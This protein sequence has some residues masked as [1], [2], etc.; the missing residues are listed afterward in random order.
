[1]Q[2][3]LAALSSIGSGNVVVTQAV[4][5][6]WEVR[7][8]GTLAGVYQNQMTANGSGLTG[9]TSPNAVVTTLSLGGDNGNV[10]D[11]TDPDGIDTRTYYDP[12]GRTV[13]SIQDFTN[14]AV[15]S[16]SNKTTDYSYNSA[17]MTSLTAEMGS[18]IGETTQWNYGVSTSGTPDSTI[19]SNDIVGTTEE[20]NPSTG[21]PSTSLETTVTVNNLGETLTSTDPNGT[22][23][24]YTYDV[25]G[26][27][28]ADTVTTLGT[29]VD[30][31]VMKIGTSYTTLGAPYLITSYNSSG[32]V[33]NQVED[34][35]NGLD[36]LTYQY[37]STSGAVNTSTTPYVEYEYTDLS[38]GNN[39]RL[40]AVVY[41]EGYTVNYNYASGLNNNISRLSSLSDSTGTLE[42]Y[43]YLGLDTVV[44]MDHPESG[45]DLTYISQTGGTGSAGDQ[46]TGID[47]FGRVDEQNWYDPTTSSS[48]FDVQYGYDKDSN[49]LYRNDVFNTAMSELYS[50]DSLGQITTFERG[51]LNSGH[52]AIT[53]PS[54]SETWTYDALGN[55]TQ[56]S[57]TTTGTTTVNS[58]FNYDNQIASLSSGTTPAYDADGNMTTDQS[59]L[60]YTYDAWGRLVTVKNSG[61]TTLES[62]SYDGMGDALTNT[63]SGT[64]T[65]FYYS[66]MGQVLEEQANST[67]YYIQR[68]VWSPA[69]VNKMILRDND[70]SGTGLTATG[71]GYT[72]LFAL[73]DADYNV[74]AL[75]NTSGV[76]VER[77]VYDPFGSV[78]ILTGSYGSRSSSSYN[79]VYGFQGG[80]KDGITSNT[81]F[82]A[83][84]TNLGLGVWMSQDPLGFGGGQVN[85]YGFEG[86]GPVGR[87]DPSGMRTTTPD[88]T[89][90][91][92]GIGGL[93]NNQVDMTN[94]LPGPSQFANVRLF[95]AP[96]AP[97][98]EPSVIDLDVLRQKS[99]EFI[100][101]IKNSPA[102]QDKNNIAEIRKSL[103]T[104]TPSDSYVHKDGGP[105]FQYAQLMMDW[106]HEN[107]MKWSNISAK[108]I[109]CGVR[110]T[111]NVL[112]HVIVE[113]TYTDADGNQQIIRFDGGT[114]FSA[115][116][117][118]GG[119]DGEISQDSYNKA[120]GTGG[121]L[122]LPGNKK[123]QK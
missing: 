24:T 65:N 58:T 45:I 2:S 36:Q 102:L 103:W 104:N 57:T 31:S 92:N 110:N 82:G 78:T 120:T 35:Y 109:V 116:G 85:V 43:L 5:G 59:D 77:Y 123:K 106:L 99:T 121:N 66:T 49:V 27:E 11:T 68:Y 26:Q 96:G 30:G 90:E 69:Y 13:Q 3:D 91:K 37:Q 46:Y 41:P 12:L 105:C 113:I 7:F 38:S 42:S 20:P 28:T 15:T 61:G 60:T 111:P 8:A 97:P 118:I 86:N 64:T 50:Y 56:D 53:S 9:G 16:S 74:V 79:W 117:N 19:N 10:V 47:Q 112:S 88:I 80:R 98:K 119:E 107:K 51:T 76:V 18:G 108:I 34:V 101:K 54:V 4:N 62:Y 89:Y 22:T 6:G 52:T 73:Q 94:L 32:G 1:M 63:V 75:V 40:T 55:H 48:V 67:G 21:Q 122:I 23:H 100:N 25:L 84:E 87:V 44:E 29:G 114:T 17:G 95:V 14:G 33:V 115:V 81:R 83:R 39:S 72:R 93:T 71:S 70:T